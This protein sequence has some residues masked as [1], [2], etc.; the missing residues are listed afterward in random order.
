MYESGFGW[1]IDW[2]ETGL[3]DHI[4]VKPWGVDAALL[5]KLLKAARTDPYAHEAAET[6]ARMHLRDGK[7]LPAPLAD[8]VLAWMD[9]PPKKKKKEDP[10]I[11]ARNEFAAM[12]VG[13]LNRKA[14][15]LPTRG[16][17]NTHRISGC[18]LVVQALSENGQHFSYTAVEEAWSKYGDPSGR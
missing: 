4:P 1:I 6:L 5:P 15:V 16:R 2:S 11:R 17:T 10:K 13:Y 8:F 9:A 18:D 3:Q 14:G 7:P 12:L